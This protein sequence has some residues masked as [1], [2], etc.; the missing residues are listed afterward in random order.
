MIRPVAADGRVE[1]GGVFTPI[2]RSRVIERFESAA[3]YKIVL[4]VAPAGYG[5]SLAVTQYLD[6]Q[7]E[8]YV[9][10]NLQPDHANLLGFLRG[11]T[12]ALGSVAPDAR[13]NLR[14]AYEANASSATVGK[15]L[16]VWLYSHLK[17][18]DGLIAIDDLHL[19][20]TDRTVTDFL[21]ALIQRSRGRCKWLLASRS[22]VNL[23]VGSWLAYGDMDLTIDEHDLRFTLAEAREA[24]KAARVSVRDEELEQ[25]LQL[26][27]GWPT[28][29]SFSL[30]S[31]T[32]SVDL[33]KITTNTQEMIY[34]YLAE[35]VYG[36]LTRGERE[37]LHFASYLDDIEIEV[38]RKA[39][40]DQAKG[41]IE[42]LRNKV[43][44]I[45]PERPFVYRCHDLFR[46][47]L[48]HQLELEGDSAVAAVQIRVAQTLESVNKISAAL[49][50]FA[51]VSS[52]ENVVRLLERHGFELYDQGNGDV[53]L[54][55]LG[56]IAQEIRA[57]NATMLAL[58][59]LVAADAGRL[60][61]AESLLQRAIARSTEVNL[62][63]SVAIRLAL[64]LTNQQRE[65][66][67]LL[68]PLLST[69]L[70]RNLRGEIL[71]LLAISHA[72]G[73][74]RREAK[75]A[76]AEAEALAIEVDNDQDVAKILHRLS[77]AMAR[78]GLPVNKVR[79]MQ[80]RAAALAADQGLWG[81]AGRCFS[82]LAS[83]S[84]FYEGDTTKEAWYAQQAATAS[85]K[86]GDKVNVQ[87][88]LLQLMDIEGRRGNSDRLQ[89]LEK[90][91]ATVASTDTNRLIYVVPVRAMS[92]A[93]HGNFDH[94]HRLMATVAENPRFLEFD[95]AFNAALDALFLI[96]ENRRDEAL[97]LVN[98]ALSLIEKTESALP[99]A[100]RQN[101]IARLLCVVVECLAGRRVSA[102][103]IARSNVSTNSPAVEALRCA[104]TCLMRLGARSSTEELGEH[105]EQLSDAGYGGLSRIIEIA[106]GR[107]QGGMQSSS[108]LTAAQIEILEAL[109]EGQTPKEIAQ[110]TGRS[111]FTIQ[112][113][114]QNVIKRL[115]CSGRHEAV[116]VARSRGILKGHRL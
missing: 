57:T 70:P 108:D 25:L 107:W 42:C 23:P 99:H 97:P 68:E 28:A 1:R 22:T 3:L 80:E 67:P 102:E 92:A 113:H 27:G 83:I 12:E 9:R 16:A 74:H 115:G 58:R 43:A 19:A 78:L 98:K 96:V 72:Y 30:R 48:Q 94:A 26:T 77:T 79:L 51:Q 89:A 4:V 46:T 84:L 20:E 33:R 36:G 56:T 111:L 101:E 39:G 8:G 76:I 13:R 54:S 100:L 37:L 104:A 93:W 61:R 6:T 53:V 60:D 18:Y 31:S 10:F 75:L 32:R 52:S 21:A 90:Q 110:S 44:F 2:L 29:L 85:L 59:A 69:A 73:G 5:K 88:A 65:T 87:T 14:N 38:L 49:R 91:L 114:I 66:V 45:Y 109:A 15:D 112:T 86:A 35:Q 103:R 11:F 71:S 50:L 95:R 34:R 62:R 116:S 82:S 63:T 47:F 17:G 40:F 24:A 41:T 64:I 105:L 81:L 55:A 106:V 7:E